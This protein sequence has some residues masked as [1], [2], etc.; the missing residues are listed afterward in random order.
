MAQADAQLLADDFLGV[1]LHDTEDCAHPCYENQCATDSDQLVPCMTIDQIVS[2]KALSKI[3]DRPCASQCFPGISQAPETWHAWAGALLK[4]TVRGTVVYLLL[5]HVL[6]KLFQATTPDDVVKIATQIPQTH[7][8]SWAN[9]LLQGLAVVGAGSLTSY[10]LDQAFA[11]LVRH[12]WP[13]DTVCRPVDAQHA[14][15]FVPCMRAVE[16]LQILKRYMHAEMQHFRKWLA[17]LDGH[18]PAVAVMISVTAR[19]LQ[20]MNHFVSELLALSRE[21]YFDTFDAHALLVRTC[22]KRV[23]QFVKLLVTLRKHVSTPEGASEAFHAF[24]RAQP[25]IDTDFASLRERHVPGESNERSELQRLS[26]ES[27]SQMVLIEV[28]RVS[29]SGWFA[30][31]ELSVPLILGVSLGELVGKFVAGE[32]VS[33]VF[34]GAVWALFDVA[35]P[36]T[37]VARVLA[38]ACHGFSF[39]AGDAGIR[40]ICSLVGVRWDEDVLSNASLAYSRGQEYAKEQ[41]WPT[42]AQHVAGVGWSL[43]VNLAIWTLRTLVSQL[44]QSLICK[45]VGDR[46]EAWARA[47]DRPISVKDAVEEVNALQNDPKTPPEERE[48]LERVAKELHGALEMPSPETRRAQQ[49]LVVRYMS[50][51]VTL[52]RMECLAGMLAR[53]DALRS[54]WEGL[55]E[56]RVTPLSIP[57]ASVV[58]EGQRALR[59]EA[60]EQLNRL[61]S[62]AIET[63]ESARQSSSV[64]GRGNTGDVDNRMLTLLY[65]ALAKFPELHVP[66]EAVSFFKDAK[67]VVFVPPGHVPWAQVEEMAEKRELSMPWTKLPEFLLRPE[68]AKFQLKPRS[69]E[70]SAPIADAD[71]KA[72]NERFAWAMSVRAMSK[73]TP[74]ELRTLDSVLNDP[75][76]FGTTMSSFESIDRHLDSLFPSNGG[77]QWTDGYG[78]WTD[79]GR[80]AVM[81]LMAPV[82]SGLQWWGSDNKEGFMSATWWGFSPDEVEKKTFPILGQLS[83]RVPK[84][85]VSE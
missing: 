55:E 4:S 21:A 52:S 28:Q 48:I 19:A 71:W 38:R 83:S 42:V 51:S 66:E 34:G 73:I 57:V 49:E 64:S 82:L 35:F 62:M 33:K 84:R 79:A 22:A 58:Q 54:A 30:L 36:W 70:G 78:H 67:A 61:L 37:S 31:L 3:P 5:T 20:D 18:N 17:L 14:F 43:G 10:V 72:M 46:L 59:F 45:P 6:P 7:G 77:V 25:E 44:V 2:A 15:D 27:V 40:A 16:A 47:M 60:Q 29:T 23:R 12:A 11:I 63:V 56:M 68:N 9:V 75:M 41:G 65:E 50:G 80:E 74:D 8:P 24:Q 69:S 76:S 39:S 26:V 85:V 1:S 13:R 32:D 81:A 53:V